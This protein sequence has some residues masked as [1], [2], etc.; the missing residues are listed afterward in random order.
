M[1]RVIHDVIVQAGRHFH[2]TRSANEHQHDFTQAD[3]LSVGND[4]V[5]IIHRHQYATKNEQTNY[6]QVDRHLF[7]QITQLDPVLVVHVAR[8]RRNAGGIQ[9]FDGY[10]HHRRDVGGNVIHP[11]VA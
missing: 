10:F 7:V 9:A 1:R 8:H 11:R 3:R 4:F 5:Q 6:E 2:Q